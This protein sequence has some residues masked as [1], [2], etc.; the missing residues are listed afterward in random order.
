MR[1]WLL[2]DG[3]RVFVPYNAANQVNDHGSRHS[4]HAAQV[5]VPTTRACTTNPVSGWRLCAWLQCAVCGTFPIVGTM[6]SCNSPEVCRTK[7]CTNCFR[8]EQYA[9]SGTCS[10]THPFFA[11]R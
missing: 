9:L 10:L 4:I 6:F 8:T 1:R 2:G 7:L 5:W 11:F 3:D